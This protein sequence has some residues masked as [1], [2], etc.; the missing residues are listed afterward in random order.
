MLQTCLLRHA[1]AF[2]LL[3]FIGEEWTKEGRAMI[4]EALAGTTF[5]GNGWWQ[6]GM[7]GGGGGGVR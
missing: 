3:L 7:G 4:T 6:T 1:P 5:P 2:L